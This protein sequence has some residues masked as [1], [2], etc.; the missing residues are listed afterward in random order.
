MRKMLIV[1]VVIVF[2]LVLGSD[3]VAGKIRTSDE[4]TR[5]RIN[6]SSITPVP[7]RDA[8]TAGDITWKIISVEEAGPVLQHPDAMATLETKGKFINV[9]FEV[10]N[11]GEDPKYIIDLRVIDE[12][13]R[14]YPICV[15]AYAYIGSS[16][17]CM[18]VQLLPDVERT[19]TMSH[20]VS[21]RSNDLWLEVTDLNVPP[22]EKKYIELGI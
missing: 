7:L 16:E 9:R 5:E 10:E 15:Q 13:G 22:E 2:C 12:R 11:H 8:V 18:L 17:A 1:I 20:D 14:T 19:F 3:L 21:L 6:R 4:Y